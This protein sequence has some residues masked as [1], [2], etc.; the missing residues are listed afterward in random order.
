[1][2]LPPVLQNDKII[3]PKISLLIRRQTS[4]AA[5]LYSWNLKRDFV[6]KSYYYLYN[7]VVYRR[8]SATVI[9]MYNVI[10]LYSIFIANDAHQSPF[11]LYIPFAS[12]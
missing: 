9:I 12:L 7:C 3:R 5:R 4:E 11:D 2:R 10:L 6:I 1:M 8:Q